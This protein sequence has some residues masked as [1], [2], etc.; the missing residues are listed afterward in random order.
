MNNVVTSPVNWWDPVTLNNG[1]TMEWHIGPLILFV[2]R[3]S[4]EWQIAS[5]RTSEFNEDQSIWRV[6][7]VDFIPEDFG[8]TSR[9]VLRDTS[10]LLTFTPQ[11]ADRP[12]ISRPISPFSV[13][14]GEE[15]TLYVSSP[16]WL[17]LF[18]GE[19]GKSGKKLDE[20]AIQR[21]SDTWFGPSTREGELCYASNTHCRLSLEELPQRSHRAI[22]P[23]V[24]RN[25]ANSTL[26][27]ERL[28]LPAPN[29]SLYATSTGQ[30][31]TPK[32]TLTREEDDELAAINID[33]QAPDIAKDAVFI[34]K[35]RKAVNERM[36]I[37][38]FNAVFS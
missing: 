9:F 27:L 4:T 18:V 30:L 34:N 38:A 29:L 1:Q 12:I 21:P 19:P 16:L 8:D 31:W 37:R 2:R 7:E 11:L 35:P 15:V 5:Q 17:E 28:N 22:T 3:L 36:L 23:I 32:I 26:T 10:G 25:R 20:I 6:S 13:I 33:H 24:L 14:A